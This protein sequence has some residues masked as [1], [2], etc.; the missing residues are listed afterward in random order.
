VKWIPSPFKETLYISP[1]SR[2]S[3]FREINQVVLK[4]KETHSLKEIPN[5]AFGLSA[6]FQ[7]S[8]VRPMIGINIPSKLQISL[9]GLDMA[10]H[11]ETLKYIHKE[12]R[13]D[14]QWSYSRLPIMLEAP[15]LLVSMVRPLLGNISENPSDYKDLTTVNLDG[16]IYNVFLKKSEDAYTRASINP[17][18]LLQMTQNSGKVQETSHPSDI[19]FYLDFLKGYMLHRYIAIELT[20]NRIYANW[21]RYNRT[22]RISNTYGESVNSAVFPQQNKN[23][24]LNGIPSPEEKEEGY[25]WGSDA[26]RQLDSLPSLIYMLKKIELFISVESNALT[27]DTKVFFKDVPK[28]EAQQRGETPNQEPQAAEPLDFDQ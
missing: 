21:R 26:S 5:S 18:A 16:W 14:D 20:K 9:R 12:K 27:F 3:D 25:S 8:L 4:K 1:I 7:T 28:T 23:Y 24:R 15:T 22:E 19:Y 17:M 11:V 13:K 10:P 2:L 6:K